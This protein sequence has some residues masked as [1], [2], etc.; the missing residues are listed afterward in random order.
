MNNPEATAQALDILRSGDAFQWYVIP[1]LAL[2]MYVYANE[3]AQ[4]NWK[5]IAA[6]LALYGVHWFFE[7]GNALIQHFSGHALWTVPTGTSF[8]LLV[9]VGVEL[10]LM[11][12]VA[13]LIM[14]KF[15]PEDPAMRI[16]GIPNRWVFAVGNAAFFAIFEIFLAKTPAFVWVYS[17]WGRVAGV[18]AGLHPILRRGL[19]DLRPTPEPADPVHRQ[20]VRDRRGDAGAVRGRAGLDLTSGTPS[21]DRQAPDREAGDLHEVW[22]DVAIR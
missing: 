21:R 8:L 1:M 18:R 11:F 17:W 13:G 22:R 20:C 4:R 5:P 6:G 7:I 19:L 10:S 14:S 15:L 16:L 12:S 9:G 3:Y 2:V